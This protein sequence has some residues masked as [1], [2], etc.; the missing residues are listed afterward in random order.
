MFKKTKLVPKVFLSA[1]QFPH[2]DQRILH[3]PGE[4]AYCDAFPNWQDLR[5]AWGISFTG[6]EPE[7]TELPCPADYARGDT[8]NLWPGNRAAQNKETT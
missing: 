8:H 7:G 3:A 2:C 1:P 6:W 5:R 4:C